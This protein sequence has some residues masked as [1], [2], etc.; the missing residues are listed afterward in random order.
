MLGENDPGSLDPARLGGCAGNSSGSP[1]VASA[2]SSRPTQTSAPT[3]SG[4]VSN[5]GS[6]SGGCTQTC[7]ANR[8]L[9]AESL[10]NERLAENSWG[11]TEQAAWTLVL[12]DYV[13]DA[14]IAAMALVSK[15]MRR[16]VLDAV[17]KR[18]LERRLARSDTAIVDADDILRLV[19]VSA[20]VHSCRKKGVAT[21]SALL[22]V[23]RRL[24]L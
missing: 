12:S 16:L 22:R 17:W 8:S 23:S 2:A 5:S 24:T 6:S 3:L 21:S 15:Q 13:P 11:E 19:L 9:T 20:A 4:P 10:A 14:T 18:K 1:A 7:V